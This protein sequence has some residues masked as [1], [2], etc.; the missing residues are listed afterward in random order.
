MYVKP[1]F[2]PAP[3][4]TQSASCCQF[5]VG[6]NA[7]PNSQSASFQNPACQSDPTGA[8]S[9]FPTCT[10]PPLNVAGIPVQ[11]CVISASANVNGVVGV[12]AVV[13][14]Y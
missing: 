2:V 11:L 3:V 4:E 1:L 6:S 13:S 7:G 5:F 8:L 14:G 10:L 12:N 9:P